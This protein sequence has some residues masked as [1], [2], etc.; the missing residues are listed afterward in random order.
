VTSSSCVVRQIDCSLLRERA[1]T[2]IPFP[3]VLIDDFL[4]AEFA[5]EVLRSWPSYDEAAKIGKVFRSIN[6]RNKVQVT[7]SAQFPPALKELNEALASPA[8]VE[9]VSSIF[10]IP[11]LLPDAEL[12]GGGLHQT[13]PR[14]RLDVHVDFDYIQAR[15]LHRRLNI[16]IFFNDGWL[17]EWGGQLEL[18]N[19]DVSTRIHCFEPLF[20]RCVIFE[21]SEIS[22]H[23]VTEVT[24]P[25]D[26]VRRSFAGYY[27][28]KAAPADWTGQSHTTIFKA[29]PEETLKNRMMA[30]K[31]V[32]DM[33]KRKLKST[34]RR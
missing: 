4:D 13:G 17:P 10:N 15:K 34:I 30:V 7:N 1:R 5:R 33:A 18:W 6:E 21:T 19:R 23:G 16:L 2:A 9:T 29:R 11:D 12:V 25:K 8:F 32:S 28:T 31:Q 20:N 3:H 26:V 14:G 22:Y 24:C 27:Y